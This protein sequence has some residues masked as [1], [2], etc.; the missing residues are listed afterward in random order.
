MRF[1]CSI[2]LRVQLQMP[3]YTA[4]ILFCSMMKGFACSEVFKVIFML[5]DILFTEANAFLCDKCC[6]FRVSSAVSLQP[7][8]RLIDLVFLLKMLTKLSVQWNLV[9]S[10]I[11]SHVQTVPQIRSELEHVRFYDVHLGIMLIIHK[12]LCLLHGIPFSY[13]ELCSQDIMTCNL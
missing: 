1:C 3:S 10:W 2:K 13:N 5:P 7:Y 8:K 9:I 12:S 11:R 6:H 4:F